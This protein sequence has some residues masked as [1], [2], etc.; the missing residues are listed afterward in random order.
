MVQVS[1]VYPNVGEI[2]QRGGLLERWRLAEELV[3]DYIEIPADFIKNK[4]EVKKTNLG[5]GEFLSEKAISQLYM[6]ELNIPQK[7]R[8][9]LHTEPSLVRRN[10]NGL[11]YQPPLKWYEENWRRKLVST[12]I[13]IS[14][15]YQFPASVIEIHPGDRR[16]E[17]EH[18]AI[19][20]RLL[21]EEYFKEF[22]VEPLV[23]LENRTE[24]FISTGE[25]I[26]GFWKFLS[27]NHLDLTD[28]VGVVLDIQQLYT[29]TKKK[30]IKSMDI[31]PSE[32]IKGFHIHH[33][34]MVP[35]LRDEIPWREVFAI[36]INMDHKVLINPEIHHK[37]K[38]RDA[39]DFCKK[40]LYSTL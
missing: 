26:R 30:F 8:Y 32:A 21:Q 24:Q 40:S 17:F 11:S 35:C 37:N 16:N 12:I 34:H 27:D 14:R 36:I 19:S 33:K 18:L 6:N 9:I 10:P 13:S 31:I 38:V 22:K 3:C 25:N 2:A 29:R 1:Y 5:I 39:I 4:N 23:L 15:F 20:M 7:L 28:K